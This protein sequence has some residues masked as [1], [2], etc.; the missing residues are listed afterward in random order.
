MSLARAEH[1]PQRFYSMS[2][3]IRKERDV[4]YDMLEATQKQDSGDVTPWLRWFLDCLDRAIAGAGTTLATVLKKAKFWEDHADGKFNQRQRDIINRLLNG[5]E[6]KLNSSK[7]AK[8]GKC[9]P[10]TALRDITELV[11]R[12]ILKKEAAGGRSTSYVLRDQ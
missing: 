12:G 10:D 1:S 5:F 6:G 9:S 11:E 7:W 8:I 4:Y 2:S 3:R